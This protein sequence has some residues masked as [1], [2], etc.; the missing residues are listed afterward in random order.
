MLHIIKKGISIMT[1][2][3]ILP[4]SLLFAA[5]AAGHS[6]SACAQGLRLE[7]HGGWDRAQ[8]DNVKSNGLMYGLGIGYDIKLGKGLFAG[9]EANADFST[10]RECA[11]GIIAAGDRL[12]VRAGRDLSLIARAGVEVT[13]GTSLYAL[14]GWSNA[15]VRGEYKPATGA[16]VTEAQTLDGWRIG[17]GVQQALGSRLYAK[18][19]YRYSDYDAGDN[20]H[21]VM[22]GFGIRF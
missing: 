4:M 3:S 10:A 16:L 7:A 6:G 17:A 18:V 20:R 15:R 13:P 9:L 2:R 14:A 22:A 21:Q 5:V 12:C 1:I 8:S 19:E 11:S